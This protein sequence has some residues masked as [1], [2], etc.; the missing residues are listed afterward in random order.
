MVKVAPRP[1]SSSLPSSSLWLLLLLLKTINKLTDKVN[2]AERLH[3]NN[4][5]LSFKTVKFEQSSCVT[6]QTYPHEPPAFRKPL[7]LGE[8]TRDTMGGMWAMNMLPPA[9]V[10]Q[11]LLDVQELTKDGESE[12]PFQGNCH[13]DD[14]KQVA[15]VLSPKLTGSISQA[16][17]CGMTILPLHELMLIFGQRL[18]PVLYYILGRICYRAAI[19]STSSSANPGPLPPGIMSRER[20]D[21]SPYPC[22]I[23]FKSKRLRI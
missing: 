22:G 11:F 5:Q 13:P 23:F 16:Q 17:A 8:L 14:A 18:H 6:E 2:L 3:G 19:T 1:S 15:T 7:V 4:T 10:A 20:V 12:A 21:D 9:L